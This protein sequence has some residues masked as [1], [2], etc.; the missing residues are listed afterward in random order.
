MEGGDDGGGGATEGVTAGAWAA[1][2][3]VLEDEDRAPQ[4]WGLPHTRLQSG[5]GQHRTPRVCVLGGPSRQ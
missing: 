4:D 3:P 2:F 1:P 5:A